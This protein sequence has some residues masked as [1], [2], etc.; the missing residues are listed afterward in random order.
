FQNIIELRTQDF[1]DQ[2]PKVKGQSSQ[3]DFDREVALIY[4]AY[5]ESLDRFGLTDED[6]D[7]LR[8]LQV[9]RGELEGRSVYLP[10]LSRIDLLVLD[11]FF[12]FTP[13]Q[14]EMLRWLI[15]SVPNVIVNLN[16]DERNHEIFRPFHSTIEH[17]MA[18]D[19]FDVRHSSDKVVV[20]GAVAP[21]RERLFNSEGGGSGAGRMPA[22]RL[23]DAGAPSLF[24]CSDR[25]VEIRSIA[26]EIKSLVLK[27]GYKLSEIAVVVRERS[28]YEEIIL[29]V[30]AD[31][32]IPCNLERRVEAQQIPAV[33]A[34]GKLF[35]LLKETS[36]EDFKNPRASDLA[37]LIKTG[38]F[39]L[40]KENLTALVEIFD[41]Q[42]VALLQDKSGTE[43]F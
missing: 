36:R 5:S 35:Q 30:C 23:Q 14:G 20:S 39:S 29:R 2:T 21:L 37:H 15:P 22:V 16:G 3:L 43:R 4:A 12:D 28:A 13:V 7:Q 38:Y 34:C 1:Q 6:A 24:E 26:K 25:E 9:L 8:A 17:L 19:G 31:E 42:F 11:G 41:K 18:I 32:S 33:R 40:P 10:W 27:E